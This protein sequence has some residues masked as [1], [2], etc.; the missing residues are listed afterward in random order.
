MVGSAL[1]QPHNQ[2]FTFFV[3]LF[4]FLHFYLSPE[5][6]SFQS[7]ESIVLNSHRVPRNDCVCVYSLYSVVTAAL[8]CLNPKAWRSLIMFLL[9]HLL[10]KFTKS[11]NLSPVLNPQWESFT[12]TWLWATDGMWAFVCGFGRKCVLEMSFKIIIKKNECFPN[13]KSWCKKIVLQDSLKYGNLLSSIKVDIC[14]W[15]G[16][17]SDFGFQT[18]V[19]RMRGGDFPEL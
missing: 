14:R 2:H 8:F 11:M 18:C 15:V 3:C 16:H 5:D 10:H 4:V 1:W 9:I 17:S 12:G 6:F 19:V 13:M 7:T